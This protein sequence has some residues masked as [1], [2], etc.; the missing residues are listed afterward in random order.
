MP[1]TVLERAQLMLNARLGAMAAETVRVVRDSAVLCDAWLA[2]PGTGR[3]E[4]G[5]EGQATIVGDRR[6][7]L[8][9]PNDLLLNGVPTKPLRGDLIFR[10]RTGYTLVYEVLPADGENT[11]SP[12]GAFD[13]RIRVH[14]KLIERRPLPA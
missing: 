5:A 1:E 4:V 9:D 10:D 6:D 11:W 3:A 12:A 14:T 2:T 7:W 8:G 13:N